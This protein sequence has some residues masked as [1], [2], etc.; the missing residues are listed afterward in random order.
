MGNGEWR[1]HKMCTRLSKERQKE[2]HRCIGSRPESDDKKA[3]GLIEK[4]EGEEIEST[5]VLVLRWGIGLVGL[6]AETGALTLLSLCLE[7]PWQLW[8]LPLTDFDEI[9]W[10]QN[11]YFCGLPYR[12][13][14]NTTAAASAF[15]LII[16]VSITN[17]H[18]SLGFKKI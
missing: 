13:L 2:R 10:P 11:H 1:D 7:F 5:V 15:F 12:L 4:K 18:N 16:P 6:S 8:P 3:K 17:T 9:C 14:Y